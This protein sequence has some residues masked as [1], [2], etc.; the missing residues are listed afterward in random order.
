MTAAR[1]LLQETQGKER[2]KKKINK[3]TVN[4]GKSTKNQEMQGTL[5]GNRKKDGERSWRKGFMRER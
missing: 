3:S 4:A 5:S 2:A 1:T